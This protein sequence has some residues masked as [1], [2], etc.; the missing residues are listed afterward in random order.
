MRSRVLRL[1]VGLCLILI[2]NCVR[3]DSTFAAAEP[4]FT[5]CWSASLKADLHEFYYSSIFRSDPADRFK[6][7]GAYT[8]YLQNTY[9]NPGPTRCP[10]FASEDAAE[11]KKKNAKAENKFDNWESIETGWSYNH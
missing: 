9:P 8:K 10:S 3:N 6:V 4:A 5:W 1:A 7:E 2:P 11:A